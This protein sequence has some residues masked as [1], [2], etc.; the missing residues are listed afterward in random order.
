[1]S[2]P[3]LGRFMWTNKLNYIKNECDNL[4]NNVDILHATIM[5]KCYD[6]SQNGG[7]YDIRRYLYKNKFEVIDLLFKDIHRKL[8]NCIWPMRQYCKYEIDDDIILE[9]EDETIFNQKIDLQIK[10][11]KLKDFKRLTSKLQ[12][13]TDIYES[14]YTLVS[15]KNAENISINDTHINHDPINDT[16]IN[17]APISHT[18]INRALDNDDVIKHN[19]EPR[20]DNEEDNPVH[21][22]RGN[23]IED[24]KSFINSKQ[25]VGKDNFDMDSTKAVNVSNENNFFPKSF[26]G[27]LSSLGKNGSVAMNSMLKSTSEA[28]SSV[29]KGVSTTASFLLDDSKSSEDPNDDVFFNDIQYTVP[30]LA[31]RYKELLIESNLIFVGD[32]LELDENDKYPFL[33]E[34][35]S[36]LLFF[37]K[38]E[39]GGKTFDGPFLENFF[40]DFKDKSIARKTELLHPNSREHPE[41]FKDN[42]RY[43]FTSLLAKNIMKKADFDYYAKD[44]NIP[45]KLKNGFLERIKKG[46]SKIMDAII[47]LQATLDEDRVKQS[48]QRKAKEKAEEARRK[49]KENPPPIFGYGGKTK[50]K[51]RK[52]RKSKRNRRAKSFSRRTSVKKK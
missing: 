4:I 29:A 26:F 18:P 2:T 50:R 39:R 12:R 36:P 15:S 13:Y 5:K 14:F 25:D 10:K 31:E 33:L 38:Y 8:L 41:N 20:V 6:G 42:T 46:R 11:F 27:T 45:E 24:N 51:N 3:K 1:M 7:N 19:F 52:T 30:N 28:V 40:N 16:P 9:L 44:N 49:A 37:T 21:N 35:D 17:D 43:V 23:E 48:G 22:T 47:L 32:E 34:S